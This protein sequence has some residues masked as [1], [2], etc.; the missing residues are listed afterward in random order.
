MLLKMADS[1]VR[2]SDDVFLLHSPTEDG[3]GMRGVRARRGTMQWAEVRP[4]REGQPLGPAELVRLRPRPES[5]RLL[6]VDVQ[7]SPE[8]TASTGHDGP[9]RVTSTAYRQNWEAVF[10][11]SEER[12]I[13]VKKGA[14]SKWSIN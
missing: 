13:P 3:G 9:A 1:S 5:P 7:Y 4:V 6:D 2:K 12:P 11:D 8:E 14:K 10:G